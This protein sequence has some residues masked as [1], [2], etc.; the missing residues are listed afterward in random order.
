M[1]VA[2]MGRECYYCDQWLSNGDLLQGYCWNCKRA[3]RLDKS[4]RNGGDGDE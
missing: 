3:T 2:E 4:A 1:G